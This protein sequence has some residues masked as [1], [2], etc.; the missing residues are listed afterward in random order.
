MALR[1]TNQMMAN[2]MLYN[3][4]SNLRRLESASERML[5][6]D[7]RRPSDDPVRVVNALALRS[8]LKEAEQYQS[9][10]K[11]AQSWL[12]VTEDALGNATQVLQRARDLAVYGATDTLPRESRQALAKEVEQLRDQLG[13]IANTVYG[14]SYIFGGTKTD[15]APYDNGSWQG[16]TREIQFEIAAGVRMTVNIPGKGLFGGDKGEGAIGVLDK[17]A[18]LLDNHDTKGSEISDMIGDID[19]LL[20][21]FIATSGEIGAK[22]NRL[23]LSMD[24]LEQ[25]EVTLNGLLS[26]AEDSDLAEAIVDLRVQENVYQVTL[27][28]GARIIMPTLIDF[29]R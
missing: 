22:V 21:N 20:D 26:Q 4:H 12:E 10:I 13:M 8:S 3:M 23:E 14:D 28:A 11:N 17:L 27:A 15:A 18:E 1:V 24:R 6:K 9:N 19:Q 2:N 29:L 16:N 7:V 5:G 25:S